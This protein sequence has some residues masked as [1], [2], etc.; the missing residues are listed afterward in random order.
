M[1]MLKEKETNI[2]AVFDSWLD[3]KSSNKVYLLNHR[4]ELVAVLYLKMLK[5]LNPKDVSLVE[6]NT[7]KEKYFLMISGIGIFFTYYQKGE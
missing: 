6:N 5:S 7:T 2:L 3:Q 4:K 1:E